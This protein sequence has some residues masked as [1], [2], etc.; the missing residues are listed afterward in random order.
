M[1]TAEIHPPLAFFRATAGYCRG[2]TI[3]RPGPAAGSTVGGWIT[4]YN[5]HWLSLSTVVPGDFTSR[6][7][8]AAGDRQRRPAQACNYLKFCCWPSGPSGCL[9][10]PRRVRAGAGLMTRPWQL[11]P[12]SPYSAAVPLLSATRAIRSRWWISPRPAGSNLQPRLLFLVYGRRRHLR[13]HL[14]NP[15]VSGGA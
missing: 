7:Q 12:G 10:Y 2:D 5:W 9:E 11:P 8:A 14:F 6:W 1:V 15:A 3:G 13:H 4:N